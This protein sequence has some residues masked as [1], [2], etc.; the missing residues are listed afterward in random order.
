MKNYFKVLGA[1][2]R[3]PPDELHA[4]YKRLA[5]EH[6]PDR[7]GD[8]AVFAAINEAYATLRDKRRRGEYEAALEVYGT[9][10]AKCGGAGARGVAKGLVERSYAAC[11]E[12]EGAGVRLRSTAAH[13][14]SPPKGK[15]SNSSGEGVIHMAAPQT[16]KGGK[17]KGC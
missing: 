7:G 3:T 5:W 17:K 12:C 8:A 2:R 4:Q 6:H 9:P 14:G 1:H 13:K 15:V 16:K 10:C 11:K